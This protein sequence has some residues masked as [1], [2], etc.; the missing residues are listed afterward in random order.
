M[1]EA[2]DP[3]HRA[4]IPF[5]SR[6]LAPGI[7]VREHLLD[8]RDVAPRAKQADADEADRRLPGRH[9]VLLRAGRRRP[10]DLV[11][12]DADLGGFLQGGRGNDASGAQDDP[13]GL[14]DLDPQP[15]RLLVK[16]RRW[17]CQVLD[18]KAVLRGLVVE[19]GDGFPA[20]VRS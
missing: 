9:H 8:E 19:D 4:H 11:A 13:V 12:G 10:H 16:P 18:R 1:H 20:I 14:G 6:S 15:G 17:H 5:R 3:I 2:A 7:D